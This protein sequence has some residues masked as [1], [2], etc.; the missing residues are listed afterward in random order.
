[1][2]DFQQLK[3]K[4]SGKT[5]KLNEVTSSCHVAL[6]HDGKFFTNLLSSIIHD[7]GKTRG[8]FILSN[9]NIFAISSQSELRRYEKCHI[10][11]I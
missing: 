11:C 4:T 8:H 9:I 5:L 3:E 2:Y 6:L 10:N 1:M 7:I